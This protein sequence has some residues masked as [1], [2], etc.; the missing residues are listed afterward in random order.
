MSSMRKQINSN[1]LL[2]AESNE[3][4][5]VDFIQK[6]SK[7]KWIKP[8]SWLSILFIFIFLVWSGI[9]S[10]KAQ[11]QNTEIEVPDVTNLSLLDAQSKLIDSKLNS[12]IIYEENIAEKDTVIRQ[13][14]S[15]M[16]VLEGTKVQLFVS[17]GKKLSIMENYKSKNLKDV[18]LELVDGLGILKEKI[19]VNYLYTDDVPDTILKQSPLANDE[20]DPASVEVVLTVSKGL[21]SF[22]MPDLIGLTEAE[23]KA[24]IELLDLTLKDDGITREKSYKYP[25][26]RVINQSPYLY[27]DD[28]SP[29]SEIKIVISDGLPTDGGQINVSI[30]IQPSVNGQNSSFTII[31]TD[32]QYQDFVYRT[33]T[34]NDQK[35]IDVRLIVSPTVNAIILIKENDV[36]I[37]TITKTYQDFLDSN[38]TS[39][40]SIKRLIKF[41]GFC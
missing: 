3:T 12:I 38:K 30:P 10:I 7:Y 11:F 16:K 19:K 40:Q 5:E 14:P 28:V 1:E 6:R 4:K 9:Q 13:S 26:G 29:K 22:K 15:K 32:A 35:T 27:N 34:I 25:K 37:N 21:E 31:V 18:M 33:L 41:R 8:I 36:L 17:K 2:D 39:M 20:F 24:Q 23:A